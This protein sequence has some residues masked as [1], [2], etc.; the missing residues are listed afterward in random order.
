MMKCLNPRDFLRVR[1]PREHVVRKAPMNRL[2]LSRRCLNAGLAA[3]LLATAPIASAQVYRWIDERG[4]V[5]YGNKPP[6]NARNVTPMSES[7]GKVSTV[8]GLT[9]QQLEASRDR[10][11]QRRM[12]RL[13]RDLEVE[14]RVNRANRTQ[15]GDTQAWLE[16]CRAERRVDCDDIARGTVSPG[17]AWGGPAWVAPPVV[18]PPQPIRPLPVPPQAQQPWPQGPAVVPSPRTGP[19][20]RIAGESGS[21]IPR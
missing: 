13:E 19:G 4:G 2:S 12:D 7:D 3:L 16:Q 11:D 17:Y 8:P 10:A 1:H 14:R 6:A 5:N 20:P 21:A 15:P 18:R 9:P